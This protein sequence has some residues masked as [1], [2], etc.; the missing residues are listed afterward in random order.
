MAP[1]RSHRFHRVGPSFHRWRRDELGVKHAVHRDRP[2][3]GAAFL[4]GHTFSFPSGHAMELIIGYGMLVY[5][6]EV[7]SQRSRPIKSAL[8][9]LMGLTVAAIGL[10]RV[11]LGVHYPS[12][13]VGGWVAGTTWL[14]I[15]V[16]GSAIALHRHE[17]E[18][19]P[20]AIPTKTH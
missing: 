20:A 4:H 1:S 9:A 12:D 7:M 16:S 3:F 10:S 11:C 15:C 5:V 2:A 8:H 17:A 14:S 18:D 6:I 19:R 13:V